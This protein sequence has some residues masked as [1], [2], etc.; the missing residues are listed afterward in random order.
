MAAVRSVYR[1][2]RFR[3]ALNFTATTAARMAD[4]GRRV[5]H[6]ILK[7]AVRFGRRSPDPQGV[8]GAFRYAT[9]MIRNGRQ[10]TLEVVLRESDQ[11]ILHFLYR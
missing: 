5:P 3:G 7:L 9:P 1:A 11:T 10:Y 6:H 2:I 4:P 8:A